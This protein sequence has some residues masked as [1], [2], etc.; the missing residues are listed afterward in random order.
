M[1]ER[2]DSP[3]APYGELLERAG[4]SADLLRE[5]IVL[6]L[7]DAPTLLTAIRAGLAA[8]DAPATRGS[9]HA[10]KGSAANFGAPALVGL[11]RQMEYDAAAGNLDAAALSLAGLE[12]ELGRL[13]AALT[14]LISRADAGAAEP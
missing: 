6:F 1:S 4:G 2:Q 8:G 3:L 11:A 12:S 9:A 13:S 14:E 7:E 10:L 5:V